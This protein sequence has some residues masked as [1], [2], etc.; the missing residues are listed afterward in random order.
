MSTPSQEL[1]DEQSGQRGTHH[2]VQW[3]EVCIWF[4]VLALLPTCLCIHVFVCLFPLGK[5]VS[6]SEPLFPYL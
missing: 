5:S 6:L 1:R 2:V 3:E 4:P